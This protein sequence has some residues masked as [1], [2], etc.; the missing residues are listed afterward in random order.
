MQGRD[1]PIGP[2]REDHEAYKPKRRTINAYLQIY[3]RLMH[4]IFFCE[5]R[6][7]YDL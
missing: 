5:K 7:I 4:D 6:F 1:Q 3:Y 2:K